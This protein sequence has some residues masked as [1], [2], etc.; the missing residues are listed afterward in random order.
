MYLSPPPVARIAA[1]TSK[2]TQ[3]ERGN[4]A[5]YN[6]IKP[7][8]GQGSAPDPAGSLQRSPDPVA[9]GEGLAAPSPKS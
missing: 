3:G 2:S 7:F 6:A 9:G 1:S 5:A 4:L 8:R